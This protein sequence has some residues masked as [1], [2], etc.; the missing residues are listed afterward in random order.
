[1][2]DFPIRETQTQDV[3]ECDWKKG[4]EGWRAMTYPGSKEHLNSIFP[5]MHF[6][7]FFEVENTNLRTIR[8][9]HFGRGVRR[10][11][12]THKGS[13]NIKTRFFENK[14]SEIFRCAE[15]EVKIS[16]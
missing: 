7:T 6:S 14:F 4:E 10:T 1:M 3:V 8:G 12:M 5:K 9:D 2:R 13:K 11:A 16:S 15:H